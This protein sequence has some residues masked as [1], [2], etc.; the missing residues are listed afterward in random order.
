MLAL[1][2]EGYG[3]TAERFKLLARQIQARGI[4]VIFVTWHD[5][6]T[7]LLD[8]QQRQVFWDVL[9]SHNVF[10]RLR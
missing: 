6:N 8:K 2:E 9:N 7:A 1:V 10:V 4:E 5:V 3:V